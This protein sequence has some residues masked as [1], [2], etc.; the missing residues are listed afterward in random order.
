MGELVQGFDFQWSDLGCYLVGIAADALM[1]VAIL[2]WLETLRNNSVSRQSRSGCDAFFSRPLL[3]IVENL[4]RMGG[5]LVIG[6]FEKA[7]GREMP[8]TRV[9]D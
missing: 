3:L 6:G 4:W 1:E 5:S 8:G 2:R 7:T 9:R